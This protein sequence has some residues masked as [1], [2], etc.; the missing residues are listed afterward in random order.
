MLLTMSAPLVMG[1][2]DLTS[3]REARLLAA[4]NRERDASGIPLLQWDPALAASA[5]EWGEHLRELGELVHSE[6]DPDDDDPEGENLWS[7]TR[8]HYSP[9]AMVGLWVE[10]K[11]NF[12]PGRF[13]DNS[14]TGQVQDV[15]HYTQVMWRRT[16][17]VGCAVTRNS[18]DEFLVCRY[19]EGGNV[20]GEQ[21]F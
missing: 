2:V 8:G 1:S 6:P 9:E 5:A 11:K 21:V 10:E 15:G 4:H 18:E 7:G 19:S 3:N 16:A 14:R 12:R 20:L 13:P 17:R